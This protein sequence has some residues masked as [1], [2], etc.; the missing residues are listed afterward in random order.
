MN[1]TSSRIPALHSILNLAHCPESCQTEV[2]AHFILISS[3][4]KLVSSVVR[5]SCC[6]EDTC[7]LNP[8]F[9]II[10]PAFYVI[11]TFTLKLHILISDCL[12]SF[13]FCLQEFENN[14]ILYSL[15]SIQQTQCF[16]QYKSFKNRV[17]LLLSLLI[18][19]CLR[20]WRTYVFL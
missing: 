2:Q 1:E 12:L 15:S 13:F 8:A 6:F 20:G 14:F 5:T 4:T 9:E 10:H 18:T 16:C 7:L 19:H 17:G 11:L 3:W